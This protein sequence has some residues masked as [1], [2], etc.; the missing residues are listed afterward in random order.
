VIDVQKSPLER[1]TKELKLKAKN[2]NFLR[3]DEDTPELL[4]ILSE[5][6]S[7]FKDGFAA[8][9][10][11]GAKNAAKENIPLINNGY[12]DEVDQEQL[13]KDQLRA[14]FNGIEPLFDYLQNAKN[15]LTPE[16]L[17]LLR[18]VAMIIENKKKYPKILATV[19]SV[20]CLRILM[21]MV[22]QAVA[23][24]RHLGK[25]PQKNLPRCY[26]YSKHFSRSQ[27]IQ[28]NL[29]NIADWTRPTMRF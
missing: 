1:A 4:A 7:G 21:P 6:E 26:I 19:P 15:L 3:L 9:F 14:L 13:T 18:E 17:E 2:E 12:Y 23:G 25:N 16:S 29:E 24:A 22:K 5:Q 11:D 27:M 20:F 28:P 10:V 8:A